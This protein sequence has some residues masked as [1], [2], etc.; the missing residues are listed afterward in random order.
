MVLRDSIIVGRS[1]NNHASEEFHANAK[2]SGILVPRTDG[3]RAKNIQFF[4][5]SAG[6]YIIESSSE[7]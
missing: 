5:F 6:M 1:K 4:N 2:S 7:N 3:F